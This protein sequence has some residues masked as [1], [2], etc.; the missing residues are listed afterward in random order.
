[1]RPFGESDATVDA[2]ELRIVVG[3]ALDALEIVIGRLVLDGDDDVLNAVSEPFRKRLQRFADHAFEFSV[4]QMPPSHFAH[5][6]STI[7]WQLTARL[8]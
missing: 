1:M 8:P 5:R 2:K 7:H 6:H 3:V 4:C